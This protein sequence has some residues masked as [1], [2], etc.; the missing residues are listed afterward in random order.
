MTPPQPSAGVPAESLAPRGGLGLRRFAARRW[1]GVP[2]SIYFWGLILLLAVLCALVPDLLAPQS[3]TAINPTEILKYPSSA[4]W[5]GTDQLGRDVFS[6]VI[7]GARTALLGPLLVATV[8]VGISIVIS[9]VV[10]Y[11]GGLADS[12]VGRVVDFLYALP[13]LIVA[14]LLVGVFSGGYW[15]ALGVLVAF[16]IPRDIRLIRAAVIERRNL[17]YVEAAWTLGV[18]RRRIMFSHLLPNVLPVAITCFFLAF[19]Y[20]I[21]A[22]AALSFLGLGVEPGS[23]DWGRMIAEGRSQ[24][25]VNPWP[26]LAPCVALVLSVLSVNFVGDWLYERI[27]ERRRSR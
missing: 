13:Q 12:I 5:F 23:P 19:T 14:I 8:A 4:H 10:G 27:E 2:I 1:D 7:A 24:L 22:L 17:P 25:F 18:S 11:V 20:G 21:I 9:L 16:G 3:P 26:T 15:M 6:R